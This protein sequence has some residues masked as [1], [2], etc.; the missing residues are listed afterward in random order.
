MSSLLKNFVNQT[1]FDSYQDFRDNFKILIPENFN[2][3]YDVVDLMLRNILKKQ[4][5][6]GVMIMAKRKYS[7]SLI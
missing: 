1:D 4:H 7:P 2:F 3:A 5:W 6:Y